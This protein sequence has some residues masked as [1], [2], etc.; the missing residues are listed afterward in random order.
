MMN[1]KELIKRFAAVSRDFFRVNLKEVNLSDA[2]LV[3]INLGGANETGANC[4]PK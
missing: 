1:F 2:C 3:G 4:A